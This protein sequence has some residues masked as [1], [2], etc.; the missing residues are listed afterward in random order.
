MTITEPK[1]DEIQTRLAELR[2]ALERELDGAV[3]NA[4]TL[5]DWR[6]HFRAHPGWFCAAAAL[7]GFVLVPARR[8]KVT[9]H[10]IQDGSSE[11]KT[12]G[13]VLLGMAVNAA[14]RGATDAVTRHGRDL[15]DRYLA[16][17]QASGDQQQADYQETTPPG[18]TR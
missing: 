14:M 16:A 13:G 7:V 6:Y 5:A 3:A 15:L 12:F 1:P 4:R 11:A 8:E 10:Q 9:V 2:G 18:S 17:R